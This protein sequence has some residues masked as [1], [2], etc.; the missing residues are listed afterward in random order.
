MPVPGQN[1][2]MHE[3][4]DQCRQSS[5]IALMT[6]STSEQGRLSPDITQLFQYVEVQ[7]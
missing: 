7:V 3:T 4:L 5:V 2:A 1:D 6:S